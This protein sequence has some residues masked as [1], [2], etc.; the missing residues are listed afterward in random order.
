MTII[1]YLAVTGLLTEKVV[2][3]TGAS[4]GIGADAA[5]VF[6]RKGASVVLAAR[7]EDHLAQVT[8]EITACGEQ[9]SYVVCDVR[10]SSDVQRMVD[11]T[12]ER[13]GRLDGAF[14]NAGISQGGAA[15]ADVDEERL[16]E[17][18]AVKPQGSVASHARP[19]PGH[20]RHRQS[21]GDRQHQQRRWP[22][23]GLSTYSA[24]YAV[25][26]CPAAQPTTMG[27]TDCVSTRSRPAPPTPP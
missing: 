1:D 18:L 19:D 22:G 25:V 9:A 26:G 4:T 10:N 24:F 27:R 15:L 3:I 5:R 7:S 14:N 23:A 16:D 6:A 8:A 13:Y 12:V 21:R 17:L 11:T 20:A 2:V